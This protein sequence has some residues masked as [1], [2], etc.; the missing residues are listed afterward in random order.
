MSG[1]LLADM[2]VFSNDLSIKTRKKSQR[3]EAK[4]SAA[5]AFE[6]VSSLLFIVTEQSE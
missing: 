3:D 6:P 5:D 2:D 1:N 4:I